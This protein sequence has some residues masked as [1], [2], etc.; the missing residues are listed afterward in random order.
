MEEK[1]D[2]SKLIRS[3]NLETG[4]YYRLMTLDTKY[5]YDTSILKLVD[6]LETTYVFL[7]EGREPSRCANRKGMRDPSGMCN[8][9][10]GKYC[11]NLPRR[12]VMRRPPS[13]DTFFWMPISKLEGLFAVGE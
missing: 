3:L 11:G 10:R 9:C 12:C 7:E 1:I 2:A 8:D 6:I 5:R 4:K 13:R